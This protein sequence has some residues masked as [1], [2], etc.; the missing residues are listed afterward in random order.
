MTTIRTARDSE[1]GETFTR[2]KAMTTQGRYEEVEAEAW[3]LAALPR[4]P[5]RRRPPHWE[6]RVLATGAAVM[7]GRV[8]EALDELDT[9]IAELEPVGLNSQ[10]LRLIA[11]SNRVVA[12]SG[13]GRYAEAETEANGILREL[14]QIAHRAPVAA[15]EVNILGH[16]AAVLCGLARHEE[17]EA[18]A[19]GNLPRA[20][21]PAVGV[22]YTTLARSLNGQGRY[23]E[24][25]TEAGRSVPPPPRY[26][27]GYLDLVTA[28]A[29]Y[30]LGRRAE[31][32]TAV[33]RAL[34]DCERRLHPAHPRIREA[35]DLLGRITG[36]A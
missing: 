21:G 14:N 18:V 22:L 33:R 25:L 2:L 34:T 5:W 29:L 36:E 19:R 10:M 20:K 9:L 17:A 12:L 1:W 7:H 27:C 35:G 24:A 31:A 11:R 30:G 26:A 13:L 23:E 4:R 32:E 3:A 15:L 6:A 8:T 28:E 16:L